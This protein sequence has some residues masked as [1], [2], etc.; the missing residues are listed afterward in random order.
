MGKKRYKKHLKKD[1]DMLPKNSYSNRS[2][3]AGG[4]NIKLFH[5]TYNNIKKKIAT[6]YQ[7]KF[8]PTEAK[9]QMLNCT[10]EVVVPSQP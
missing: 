5:L 10:F 2:E 3:F 6:C 7:K 1:S 8:I 4:A 9:Q